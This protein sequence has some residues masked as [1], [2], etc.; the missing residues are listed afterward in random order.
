MYPKEKSWKPWQHKPNTSR[1]KREGEK[2]VTKFE[3]NQ[4]G[5]DRH[6]QANWHPA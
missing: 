5:S 2:D 6:T 3:I 1:P 4:Q